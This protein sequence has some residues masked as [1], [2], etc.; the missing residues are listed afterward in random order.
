[1]IWT[2]F[3]SAISIFG[4]LSEIDLE[5]RNNPSGSDISNEPRQPS[6]ENIGS[7]IQSSLSLPLMEDPVVSP[8]LD[9]GLDP[10]LAEQCDE[11]K[12]NITEIFKVRV[13]LFSLE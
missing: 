9:P 13:G 6:V 10:T 5:D 1:M 12:R 4:T 11:A 3:A 7:E 8:G 2:L